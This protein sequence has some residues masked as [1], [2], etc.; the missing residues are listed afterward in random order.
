MKGLKNY[1]V[2]VAVTLT[3]L[4]SFGALNMSS[5]SAHG[6]DTTLIHSC[7][8]QNGGINIVGANQTCGQNQ[9]ALDWNI[10]G[11]AGPIG[12]QG[13]QGVAGPIGPTGAT[14]ATGTTGPQG[15]QGVQGVQGPQGPARSFQNVLVVSPSGGDF[16]S[17]QA[18][19]NSITTN[20]STNTYLI[21]VGPGTYTEQV[22]MKPYVDIEGAGENVTR[23]TFTGN[24]SGDAGTVVGANN[25]E[26]RSLTVENTGGTTFATAIYN[27]GA[28]PSLLHVTATASGASINNT[29]VLNVSSSPTMNNVTA[30]ASGA[31]INNMG[32]LNNASSPTMTN[33]TASGSGG[34]NNYG[35]YNVWTSSATMTNATASGS[36]GSNN[37]G[38]YN[39]FTS[40]ATIDNSVI[41]GSTMTLYAS[42]GDIAKVGAS[43]LNGGPVFGAVK[44]AGV[45]DENY[46]FYPS[47]C[48]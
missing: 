9:T 8:N 5:V 34:S 14:G 29:G 35:V 46:T 19:L 3:S 24:S 16:T 2:A 37:Y 45:Y 42:A 41:T 40:T 44:C 25:A 28:S 17:I 23:I 36:G 38:V 10:Q 43:K 21:W 22:T 48:P 12:P 6:G 20:S 1:A 13:I 47:T 26:L 39:V 18:A 32:V 4:I 30:T 33:V 7:V 11:V 31:S 15:V 27:D